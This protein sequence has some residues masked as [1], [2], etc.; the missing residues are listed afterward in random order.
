MHA[1]FFPALQ[2]A[3]T[4]MS[5]SEPN[6]TIY[7]NDT[8][9]QVKNKINKHAFSGGQATVEDHRT[10]GGN[11]DTDISFQYLRFFL[12]DDDKLENIRKDY[13][14]GALLTGELKKLLID[15]L[16]PL[17]TE[18]QQRRAQITDEVLKQYMT[19]RKLCF[20]Y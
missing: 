15:I 17:L 5:A 2:G 3:Q 8:P 14:S 19:P 7:C 16:T 18:H 11:C 6:S 10:L 20:D 4:K 9:K 1:K 13:S 12:E